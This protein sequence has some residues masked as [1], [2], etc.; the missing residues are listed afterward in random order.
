MKKTIAAVSAFAVL[1]T[2][3]IAGP[4]PDEDKL[5]VEGVEIV[6]EVEAPE[7]HPLDTLY[8]G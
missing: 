1:A 8:S 6:T 4:G 5:S 7:G 3:A 2:G